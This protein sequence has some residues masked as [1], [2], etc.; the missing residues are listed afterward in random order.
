MV[1]RGVRRARMGRSGQ[2]GAAIV[3]NGLKAATGQRCG[4]TAVDKSTRGIGPNVIPK[5]LL[6][7]L[8]WTR[9][10]TQVKLML[11]RIVICLGQ[12]SQSRRAP[13]VAW[14]SAA[15]SDSKRDL[16]VP[17]GF[18]CDGNSFNPPWRS[19]VEYHW[20]SKS[21]KKQTLWGYLL[22]PF[23]MYPHSHNAKNIQKGNVML[24]MGLYGSKIY[25]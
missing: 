2:S 23:V 15:A 17:L 21:V 3:W 24:L 6:E 14:G 11:R 5:P 19:K 8:L 12:Q 13:A 22:R 9:R 20:V 10:R 16:A 4:N 1:S 25:S 18:A 7:H